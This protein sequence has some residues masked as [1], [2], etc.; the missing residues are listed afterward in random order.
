MDSKIDFVPWA[1]GTIAADGTV[2]GIAGA[3]CVRTGVGSYVVT[4]DRCLTHDEGI[5]M[6]SLSVNILKEE[7]KWQARS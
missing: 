5:F 7:G 3:S 1:A 6:I 4:L 2:N